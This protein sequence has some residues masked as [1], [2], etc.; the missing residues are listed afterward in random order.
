MVRGLIFILLFAALP[1][2][3]A[4]TLREAVERAWLRQPAAQS[5]RARTEEIDARRAA[6]RAAFPE[7]PSLR[8]GNRNDRLNR[9]Q[10][11]DEW[12]AELALPVWL[13][14]ERVRQ[15]AVVDAEQDQYGVALAAAKLRIAGEV[16]EAY[17]EARLA[18]ND[19]A[20]ARRKVE[21][22]A[23]LASDVERRFKAGDLA[24][25]DSN[26]ARGVEA[27]ARAAL[28]EAR[29]R[30]YK[31]LRSFERLTGMAALPSGAEKAEAGA[32]VDIHPQLVSLQRAVATAQAKLAQAQHKKRDNPE[33]ELGM[34]RERGAF[35]ERYQ[36]ALMVRFKLPFATDARN[37]PRVT[38]ASAELVEAEA[39][40]GLERARL[41][42]E[43]D[44]ARREAEEARTVE[45]LVESRLRLAEETRRL[46][47]RAFALG[48]LD[49]VSRLR[50]EAER[51]EAE[52]AYSRAQLEA[53][54]AVARLNQAL[55]VLP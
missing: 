11:S 23:A 18:E 45:R 35:D 15:A 22:T 49:L 8:V 29:V 1:A 37:R 52:L 6:A 43:I 53:T 4:E 14:G 10:G 28:T 26:Q 42:A 16:R 12:E 54:R 44:A 19:V 24:R 41:A 3:P 50:V 31:A 48:E 47:A 32:A 2:F 30:S 51:F 36:N 20:L 7:P 13:P 38:A 40:Y 27:G 46:Q 17:W 25:I 9:N 33:L 21:E 5:Q 34:R 39:A 55:G